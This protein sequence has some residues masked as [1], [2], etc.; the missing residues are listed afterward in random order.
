M[1]DV[2]STSQ[3]A[4]LQ[5]SDEL[6]FL[7]AVDKLRSHGVSHW[8]QLPQLIVCGDQSS[9]KSSVLEAISGIPFPTKDTLCT[10]F[11]TEVILRRTH[12]VTGT[13]SIVP[14]QSRSESDRQRLSHFQVMLSTFSDLSTVMEKANQVMGIS[15]GAFSDDVLR[16][17]ITGPDQP[18]LTIV[19]LPGLIHSKN[20][21]QTDEDVELIQ[22]LVRNYMNNKRSIILAIVTAKND[23]ANQI[24]LSLAKK[25]DPKGLRTLGII[26]KPDELPEGS[27]S[28]AAFTRLARNEDVEFRLG[29]HVVRNRKYEERDTTLDDRDRVEQEFFAKGVW[30]DFPRSA[31]GIKSLRHRLSSVLLNQIRT[32]LPSVISE[33]E[34]KL[35][36]CECNL[37]KLGPSRTS[38]KDQQKFLFDISQKFQALTKAATDGLYTDP[39]FGDAGSDEGYSRRIRAVIQNRNLDFARLIRQRGHHWTVV[40]NICPPGDDDESDSPKVICRRDMIA[41]VND[42]LS[43]S[44]GPELPGMFSPMIV[45]DLIRTQS[46]RW[47]ELAQ[48]HVDGIWQQCLT[49]LD[50]LTRFLTDETTSERIIRKIIC[51]QMDCKLK[52]LSQKLTEILTIYSESHPITYNHYFTD[53]VQKIRNVRSK[54]EIKRNLLKFLGHEDQNMEELWLDQ[55]VSISSLVDTLTTK[56][57]ADMDNYA[58]SEIL[59]CMEAYYKVS[60]FISTQSLLNRSLL[61]NLTSNRLP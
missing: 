6:G 54:D 34:G 18:H 28:E 47:A 8:I 43:R 20:K 25:Y 49:F 7:D 24:V 11:P 39:F 23:L 59:D 3:L 60:Y 35:N 5:S 40:D 10:R 44:R 19:D 12:A 56:S 16:V 37:K 48:C 13:V 4:S 46:R 17:E 2:P 30:V 33:I 53:T 9:G 21:D 1:A 58:C 27:E 15:S 31:V 38:F 22:R 42:L 36:D 41:R 45:A 29:W 57:E 61:T 32:E 26:T 50:H 51:P 52:L 14:S 55:D